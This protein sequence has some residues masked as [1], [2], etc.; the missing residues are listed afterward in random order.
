MNVPLPPMAAK[1]ADLI[2]SD[3]AIALIAHAR[4]GKG[5][6]HIYVPLRPKPESNLV[7]V[8]GIEAAKKMA[9]IHGGQEI[10][11]PKC[12][13]IDRAQ[14][15]YEVQIMASQGIAINR[16]AKSVGLT[17]RHIRNLLKE[18]DLRLSP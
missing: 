15:L 11:I 1:L 6:R 18:K 8:I 14:R 13:V 17:E 16:I 10:E 3:N 2:G 9:Q 4:Q 5:K 12:K 7:Q